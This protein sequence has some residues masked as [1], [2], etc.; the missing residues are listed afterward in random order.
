MRL[1]LLATLAVFPVIAAQAQT[2]GPVALVIHGGAGTILRAN[3]TPEREAQYRAALTE[4]LH[5]GHGVLTRGGTALDAVT[6][7]I[8]VMERSPL[9]NAGVGAVLTDAGRAELDAAIMDGATRRAGAVA[10]VTTV[11]SPV[12]L[13]RRVMD[14][15]PHVLLMG[16]GAE[17]FAREQGF[18]V[19]P[20]D[21]FIVPA[22]REQLRQLQQ[23]RRS[24]MA[25][26][27]YAPDPF[28]MIQQK[29]GTVGAVAL[30]QHGH[31]A[32]A[33]S[34][35]GLMGKRFGRV[36]DAPLIGAGTYA[37]DETCGVSAT[38]TGEFFIRGVVAHD[39]ASMMRYAGLSLKE[40]ANAVVMG[41]LRG[42]R[43]RWRGCFARP[44]GSYRDGVQ[45]AGHVPGE[46]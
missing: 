33:T 6:A 34:T 42:A 14:A 25:D 46:H 5:A 17:A 32:A 44:A 21:T 26:P 8:Q 39:I 29:Y 24:G 35:G 45:H 11:F 9:F 36:G 3:M 41:R 30:D 22:R 31:I 40:A 15:T 20:N 13:A 23:N 10:G 28:G 16:A 1:L 7:A 43:G 38:G 2:P 27:D 37:E 19:V 18:P 12:A 4:A